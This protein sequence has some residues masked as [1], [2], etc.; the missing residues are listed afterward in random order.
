MYTYIYKDTHTCVEPW[1]PSQHPVTQQPLEAHL[2]RP[3]QLHALG[4]KRKRLSLKKWGRGR[5]GRGGEGR[6]WEGRGGDL[7]ISLVL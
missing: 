4:K 6:G 7:G 5:E 3:Q 2:Q 1:V